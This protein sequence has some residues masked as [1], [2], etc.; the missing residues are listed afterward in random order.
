MK[1]AWE[2]L[3]GHAISIEIDTI[4]HAIPIN[5]HSIPDDSPPPQLQGRPLRRHIHAEILQHPIR[6]V[7][8]RDAV[9]VLVLKILPDYAQRVGANLIRVVVK[10]DADGTSAQYDHSLADSDSQHG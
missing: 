5:I 7:I 1:V 9:T 4:G 6:L 3:I 8:V 10:L 2:R